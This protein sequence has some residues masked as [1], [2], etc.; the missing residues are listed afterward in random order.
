MYV[1]TYWY[2]KQRDSM[3]HWV[4]CLEQKSAGN[5]QEF[6]QN[7]RVLE[8][9]KNLFRKLQTVFTHLRLLW[10]KLNAI[11]FMA[12]VWAITRLKPY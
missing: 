12:C 7:K 10:F 5:R 2:F 9:D 4:A 3:I 8:T 6:V 1:Y 11:Q